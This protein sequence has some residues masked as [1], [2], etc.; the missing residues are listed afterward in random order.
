MSYYNDVYL[1]RMN[2]NGNT[3]QER[4]KTK[5][6]KE[7]DFIYLEKTEY[8]ACIYQINENEANIVCSLQP[9]KWNEDQLISNLLISTK[10]SPL[11]TGD[12]LR[13]FQKIK[14]VE[15]DKIW[16]VIFCEENITKGYQT[17]K[18]ICLDE[19]I[20]ITNEYGD[21]IYS[22]P[23]KSISA[24]SSLVKD[25]FSFTQNNLGYR[26]PQRDLQ[27]ITK[28]FDFLKKGIY[29]EY[30]KKGFLIYGINDIDINNVAYV[31]ISEKLV[32]EAEPKS[33]ADIPVDEETNFFLN[34]R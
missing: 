17:Y 25:Y 3:Q 2:I 12:I 13:I 11:K 21:T 32:R 19:V 1:K 34:N 23:V 30:K 33:S 8:Q 9:N 24:S 7:F 15:Y 14:E 6:E 5:K 18:L 10:N 29:F 16:L 31:T 28:A 4:I 22:I 20:N 27:F 26:E